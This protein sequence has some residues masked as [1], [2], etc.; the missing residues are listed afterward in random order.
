MQYPPFQA[1]HG[2]GSAYADDITIFVSQRSDI[3]AV[4]KAVVRY[5]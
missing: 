1:S 2:E 5:E 3:E 4:K